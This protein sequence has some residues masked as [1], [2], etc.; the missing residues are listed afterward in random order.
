MFSFDYGRAREAEVSIEVLHVIWLNID[1]GVI[2]TK[3]Q[4]ISLFHTYI[5]YLVISPSNLKLGL[6]SG[7]SLSFNVSE[8]YF[9]YLDN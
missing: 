8:N 9:A 6:L 2:G 4:I 5:F 7:L 1:V 3:L